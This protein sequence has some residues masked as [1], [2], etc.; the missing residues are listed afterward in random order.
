MR[1][2]P[3]KGY[4]LGQQGAGG[5]GDSLGG[6]AVALHQGAGRCGFAEA[7]HADHVCL[8]GADHVFP[9]GVRVRR[10]R[11][12]FVWHTLYEVIRTPWDSLTHLATDKYWFLPVRWILKDTYDNVANLADYNGPV[13]VIMAGKDEIIPN[14]LTRHLYETLGEPKRLW[15]FPNA[16]HN[17][18]PSSPDASWWKEMMDFLQPSASV[19]SQKEFTE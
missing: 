13:A 8:G 3:D 16:G 4:S 15:T 2:S 9:P 6:E 10:F 14:R 5:V 7:I 1:K 19:V 11:N 17:S 12:N 18:W